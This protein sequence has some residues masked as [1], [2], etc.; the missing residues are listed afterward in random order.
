[1]IVLQRFRHPCLELLN[2]CFR[3]WM[4]RE[5]I[6]R[7]ALFLAFHSFPDSESSLRVVSSLRHQDQPDMI[8]LGFLG[9][10]KRQDDTHGSAQTEG[11]KN[12]RT[13]PRGARNRKASTQYLGLA[14]PLSRVPQQR[15]GHLVSEDNRQ[16]SLILGD[17]KDACINGNLA[18]WDAKRVNI[19]GVVDDTEFPL[20]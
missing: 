2:T 9:P 6:G 4:G 3:P 8:R 14:H 19:L 13:N 11:L 16:T 15:V 7:P 18:S 20:V 5:K 1:M 17:R 10:A 12:L